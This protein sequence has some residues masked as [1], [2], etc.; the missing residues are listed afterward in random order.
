MRRCYKAFPPAGL[1]V[2]TVIGIGSNCLQF[3]TQW[4]F[5]FIAKQHEVPED[6]LCDLASLP[7]PDD[8]G[9]DEKDFSDSDG[10]DDNSD[11]I[12]VSLVEKEQE[13]RV[14][15]TFPVL[16]RSMSAQELPPVLGTL[17]GNFDG[18]GNVDFV[19]LMPGKQEEG[20]VKGEEKVSRMPV[21]TSFHT[22]ATSIMRGPS[23]RTNWQ[24]FTS[25]TR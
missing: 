7:S 6:W 19:H 10:S 22:L 11:C 14:K 5:Q 21:P 23:R 17:G 2:I 25:N 15:P 12:V 1:E 13:A 18:S 9:D 16:V 3:R 20:G 24:I 8:I 4:S